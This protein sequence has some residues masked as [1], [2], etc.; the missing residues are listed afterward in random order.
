[1]RGVH[2]AT[3]SPVEDL[4]SEWLCPRG[5]NGLQGVRV[6]DRRFNDSDPLQLEKQIIAH[7]LAH[8]PPDRA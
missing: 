3:K 6:I 1:M 8:A 4:I 7:E 2:P 5:F